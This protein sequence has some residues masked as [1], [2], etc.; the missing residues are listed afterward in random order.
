MVTFSLMGNRKHAEKSVCFAQTVLKA[1][2]SV[3]ETYQSQRIER[4]EDTRCGADRT[5]GDAFVGTAAPGLL[6]CVFY[7]DVVLETHRKVQWYFRQT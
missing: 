4:D 7:A 6:R 3:P 5:I 2:N 1:W